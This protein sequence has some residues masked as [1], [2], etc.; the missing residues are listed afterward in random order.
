MFSDSDLPDKIDTYT[1]DLQRRIEADERNKTHFIQQR[2]FVPTIRNAAG[3]N[4]VQ[5]LSSDMEFLAVPNSWTFCSACN[6]I[7]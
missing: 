1:T 5:K 3:V 4:Q 6:S 7:S 2:T